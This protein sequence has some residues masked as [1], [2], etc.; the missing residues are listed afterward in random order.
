MSNVSHT[1]SDISSHP[2]AT[3]MRARHDRVMRGGG[4]STAFADAPVFLVGLYCA[5]SPWVL[6]FTASQPSLV[7]H[8]VVIGIAI[9]VLALC[10]TAIPERM[11]GMSLAISALGGWLIASTWIVGSSP[12]TGVILSNVIAGGLA[13]VLGAVCSG[14]AVMN[15]RKLSRAAR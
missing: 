14:V 11:A 6:H 9:A 7:V 1:R 15:K 13:V 4:R 5:V 12:D 3:E 2:D 8:N 10:F